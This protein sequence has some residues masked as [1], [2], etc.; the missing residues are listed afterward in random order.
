M[1]FVFRFSQWQFLS[2][3]CW[4]GLQGSISDPAFMEYMFS[5]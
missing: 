3:L 1:T 2:N 4:F 5:I